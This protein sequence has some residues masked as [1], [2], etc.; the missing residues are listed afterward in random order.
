MLISP[1]FLPPRQPGQSDE[2]WLRAAM[3]GG[4]PGDG[5]FP[6]SF[7]LGWHGGMHLTAPLI[8]ANSERV[9]AIA[10]GKVVYH[11]PATAKQRDNKHPLNYRGGWTDDGCIVLRHETAIGSGASASDIVFFSIYMHLSVV[12]PRIRVGINLRRKDELG[13]AGQ[14]YGG[15]QKKIHFEIVSDDANAKKMLGR[16]SGRTDTSKNG[17]ADAI[18]GDVYFYL[19]PGTLFYDAE[20]AL[21]LAVAQTK[22]TKPGSRNAQ[23][24]TTLLSPI[25]TSDQAMIVG[26]GTRVDRVFKP[27]DAVATSYSL[28]GVVIGA[29]LREPEADYIALR[30]ARKISN[31]F[32]AEKRPAPSAILEILRFG[33]VVNTS[34]ESLPN[35]EVPHWRLV[36]FPGGKGWVNLNAYGVTKFSDADFPQW[37]GWTIV[38]DSADKDSRCDSSV[39]KG[40]LSAVDGSS[41]RS[42][43]SSALQSPEVIKKL[44][45]SICKFP[46]EWCASTIDQR[47]SWLKEQSPARS[48]ALTETDFDKLKKHIASLCF[49]LPELN[50]AQWHWPPL[51]F[52]KHFRTCGWLSE[53]ELVRCVPAAYQ[54]ERGRRGTAT[55][56]SR[57]STSEAR[58]RIKQRNAVIF[59]EVCRKYAIVTPMRLAHFLSQ[60]YRETGVLQWNQERASGAEY[61]GRVDLGNRQPGD[62]ERYK[63][64]GL[65]QITGR[66]NYEDYSEYRG[67]NGRDS[68]IVE[69]NN[70]QLATN[71]YNCADT[72][73]LYWAGRAV[74]GGPININRIADLGIAE[75]D[76]KNVTKNV[77]GAADG[78]WTGLVERRSHLRVLVSVLFDNLSTI[79]PVLE[80]ANE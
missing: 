32:P 9:R 15:L 19:P 42:L 11:R 26:L 78:E 30:Q 4:E 39:I 6:V 55:I 61:E 53:A 31:S 28:D 27:G 43:A 1:P 10:D 59:M 41:S 14:I 18:F 49:E 79:E 48:V 58:A 45:Q 21:N 51:Q 75:E 5:A 63:G 2:A 69:P 22:T 37:A 46:S 64:R 23:P 29:P 68:F 70:L 7:D 80:R 44:S 20:P 3:V 34:N 16:S 50:K 77:N 47:W 56:L 13:Q 60:I 35:I 72:A 52:I 38:D 54:T 67:R 24:V 71:V 62:G 17:R 66:K 25:F 73:G 40:W 8:G 33:R 76:I 12:D 57:L 74:N 36:S 65:I